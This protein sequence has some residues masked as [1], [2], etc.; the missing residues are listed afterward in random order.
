MKNVLWSLLAAGILLGICG[1]EVV[2]QNPVTK[3]F[4]YQAALRDQSGNLMEDKSISLLLTIRENG[5][6][7]SVAYIESHRVTT[8]RFGMVNLEV[9]SGQD[10][11]GSLHGINWSAN[12]VWMEIALA[13]EGESNYKVVGN[14]K[15]TGVPYAM[16][17]GQAETVSESLYQELK[18]THWHEGTTPPGS[19]NIL[20]GTGDYFMDITTAKIYR[21]VENGTWVYRG[22]LSEDATGG[23]NRADPNDW[24]ITGNSGTSPATNFIGSTDN[25]GVAFRVNNTEQM[26]LNSKGLVIGQTS[27][28][29][30]HILTLRQKG[31][32]KTYG[33]KILNSGATRAA[34]F[35]VGT[36]GV[37]FEAQGASTFMLR[38]SNTDRLFVQADGKIGI[39]NKTPSEILDVTGT[40]KAAEFSGGGSGLTEVTADSL[41]APM[42]A[43]TCDILKWD[44]DMWVPAYYPMVSFHTVD[45]MGQMVGAS[46]C[47]TMKAGNVL[48]DD[49]SNFDPISWTFSAP[50]DG[51]FFFEASCT[52]QNVPDKDSPDFGLGTVKISIKTSSGF[53]HSA[54]AN[55]ESD[56]MWVTADISTNLMLAPGELVWIEICN[57]TGRSLP[58]ESSGAY[59]WFSGFMKYATGP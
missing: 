49:G 3:G 23:E 37:V 36:N 44:G 19:S 41:G 15:I 43:D 30:D 25:V 58:T 59:V 33:L 55:G 21:K 7:G 6:Q 38:T 16:Y 57:D 31:D 39:G 45:S 22:T 46:S 4:N 2:A 35:F 40:V 56:G 29:N 50:R 24:T 11:E 14:S 8:N 20:A 42:G 53:V 34:R 27:T 18:G 17:A 47:D 28:P 26:R 51:V 54:L 1:P 48:W 5:P 32:S 13:K 10:P 9:G 52:F 12:D